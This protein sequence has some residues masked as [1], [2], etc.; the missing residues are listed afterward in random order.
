[1]YVISETA[2][3][4]GETEGL[5]EISVSEIQVTKICRISLAL[6]NTSYFYERDFSKGCN[7]EWEMKL[8]LQCVTDVIL[9]TILCICYS[10]FAD[11]ETKSSGGSV[12]C[13]RSPRH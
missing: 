6:T 11:V 7:E 5:I 3:L 13:P 12:S 8:E 9:S 2:S 4:K 10:H 1:M